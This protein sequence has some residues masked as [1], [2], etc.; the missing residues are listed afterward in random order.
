M[1]FACFSLARPTDR[2]QVFMVHQGCSLTYKIPL[3]SIAPEAIPDVRLHFTTVSDM[4]VAFVPGHVM[5]LVLD[6]GPE[7][8]PC[9][10]LVQLGPAA[11]SKLPLS[12]NPDAAP[13]HVT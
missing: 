6:C 13:S 9:H 7:Y 2:P 4:L 3:A 12:D 10:H 1:S 8:S 5:L 11:A